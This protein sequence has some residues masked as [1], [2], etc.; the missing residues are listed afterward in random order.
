MRLVAR[1]ANYLRRLIEKKDEISEPSGGFLCHRVRQKTVSL[2]EE[3]GML[4]DI[5]TGEGLL[6]KALEG[7]KFKML[8]AIDVNQEFLKQAIENL[9]DRKISFIL[10]NGRLLPFKNGVFDG[11]ILL[12]LF[13]NIPK[14]DILASILKEAF[15]VCKTNGRVIF[16]YRNMI[17]PLILLSYKTVSLH[18]PDI[19][20]PLRAFTKKEIR[21]ILQ[22]MDIRDVIYYPIPSWWKVNSPAYLVEAKKRQ[23]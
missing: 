14:I 16:D 10:G 5:G 21:Y 13:L 19:K 1:L 6:L 18:D 23:Q 17:N 4:L 20:L 15:R 11:V 3:D 22:S 7:K 2:I 9:P 8:C 12:N